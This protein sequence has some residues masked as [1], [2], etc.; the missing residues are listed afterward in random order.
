MTPTPMALKMITATAAMAIKGLIL[1][2][3]SDIEPP[4]VLNNYAQRMLLWIFIPF[5]PN[6]MRVLVVDV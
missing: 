1:D 2:F 4:M 5:M 3:S 6:A